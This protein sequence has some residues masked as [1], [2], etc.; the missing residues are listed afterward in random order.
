MTAKFDAFKEA[1]LDLCNEHKVFLFAYEGLKVRDNNGTPYVK[2]RIQ[3]L[4][5]CKTKQSNSNTTHTKPA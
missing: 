3:H 1:L 2:G 5:I 4:S